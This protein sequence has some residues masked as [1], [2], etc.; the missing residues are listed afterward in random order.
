MKDIT[1]Y[2]VSAELAPTTIEDSVWQENIAL[3]LYSD[4]V[5]PRAKSVK[6]GLHLRFVRLLKMLP[7]DGVVFTRRRDLLGNAY[8]Y[9]NQAIEE[10]YLSARHSRSTGKMILYPTEQLKSLVSISKPTLEELINA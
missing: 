4:N 9:I 1:D 10:G 5:L 6:Y 7:E 3:G 2:W 8:R